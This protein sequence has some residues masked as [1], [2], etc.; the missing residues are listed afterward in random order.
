MRTNFILVDLE[1]VQ[2]ESLEPLNHEHFRV[3][4]FVGANQ[5]KLSF[6]L[7][8][9][10]QRFG[11]RAEYVKI[12]G[13]GHNALDFH[14]AFYI[15][16]LASEHANAFFHIISKDAGFDPLIQHLKTRKILA[17]RVASISEIPLVKAANSRS[18]EERTQL[19]I[20]R[21][22]TPKATRPRTVKTLS[23]SI[24]SQFQRQ[25]NEA[26]V[27]AIVDGLLKRKF[28]SVLESNVIYE[29]PQ[30]KT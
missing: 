5:T 7:A 9:A 27:Q 16:Q 24:N 29:V 12:S 25:L 30:G 17:S 28:I 3:V 23:S 1:N 22:T 11:S 20:D 10:I 15:G 14:I 6:P 2:P 4:V 13:S 21:L 19:V 18:A 26:E 8:E